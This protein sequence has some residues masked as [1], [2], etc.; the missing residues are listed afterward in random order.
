MTVTP[1]FAF[2][3]ALVLTC[4]ALFFIWKSNDHQECEETIVRT[5]DAAGNTVVEKQHYCK[6][7]FN[8]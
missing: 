5:T 8:F 1:R 2:I 4:S 7:K 3:A 6:E